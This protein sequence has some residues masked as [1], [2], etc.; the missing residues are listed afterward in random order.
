MQ[1]TDSIVV[2][3]VIFANTSDVEWL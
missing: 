1:D 3:P 2:Q